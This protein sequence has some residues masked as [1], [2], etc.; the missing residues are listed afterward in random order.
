MIFSIKL[1][2][3]FNSF[4]FSKPLFAYYS[5]LRNEEESSMDT[6][7]E[8]AKVFANEMVNLAIN[9]LGHGRWVHISVK[10]ECGFVLEKV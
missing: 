9:E 6:G 10:N 8:V 7:I 3:L 1:G 2:D 5:F 4:A